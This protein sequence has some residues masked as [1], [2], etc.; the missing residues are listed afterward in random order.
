LK[1]EENDLS[2]NALDHSSLDREEDE[3]ELEIE[4]ESC[5][6]SVDEEV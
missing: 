5:S 3:R 6:K 1:N 2:K 4:E